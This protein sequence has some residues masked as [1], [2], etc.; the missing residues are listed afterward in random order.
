MSRRSFWAAALT[1]AAAISAAGCSKP[2]PVTLEP[3]TY[4]Q[5]RGKLASMKG[6][7]VV[8]DVWATW[9]EPCVERFPHLVA[10]YRQYQGRGV[11]FVS[12]SVDD[13]EDKAAVARARE[14]LVKQNA[15]FPNYLMNENIM[16]SFDKL[17]VQGIPDVFLYDRAGKQRYDLNGNDPNHQATLQDVENDLA[18]LVAEK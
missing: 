13:R 17:G 5:W 3:V 8:L 18:A 10:L 12:M 15:A 4:D 6:H 9:C 1:L 2:R 14:F 11:D 7:I 16:E